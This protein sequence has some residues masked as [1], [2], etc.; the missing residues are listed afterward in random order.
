VTLNITRDIL[1]A[2]AFSPNVRLFETVAASSQGRPRRF[3][4]SARCLKTVGATSPQ[5]RDCVSLRNDAPQHGAQQIEE[6]AIRYLEIV[7]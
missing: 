6:P 1:Q 3:S 2:A 7:A 4:S 5:P